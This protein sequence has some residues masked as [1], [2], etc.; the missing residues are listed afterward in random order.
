MMKDKIKKALKIR[1]WLT[2]AH[3]IPGRIRLKYKMGI[4]THLVTIKVTDIEQAL[5]DIPAFKNYKINSDTGSIL[6]EYDAGIIKPEFINQL[7]S[8]S[9]IDVQ[10][11]YLNIAAS[12]K[13][14][15]VNDE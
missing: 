9:E 15:G 14:D 1:R 11:A 5:A 6:V 10:Q 13:M 7:F 4:M 3:H 8:E 2:L 12:L